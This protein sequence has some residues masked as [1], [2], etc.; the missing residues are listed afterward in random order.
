M[1]IMRVPI[2]TVLLAIT[3]TLGGA[4]WAGKKTPT[5]KDKMIGTWKATKAD[6]KDRVEFGVFTF[7]DDGKFTLERAHFL[8]LAKGTYT[9]DGDA[10]KFTVTYAVDGAPMD[11]GPW[12]VKVKSLSDKEIVLELK[13]EGSTA[14]VHF[15]RV[16]IPEGAWQAVEQD[17]QKL[18]GSW[19]HV[20]SEEAGK[21]VKDKEFAATMTFKGEKVVVTAEKEYG[22][23]TLSA[24]RK[25]KAIQFR[26]S[27]GQGLANLGA[28]QLDGDKLRIC[29]DP[30]RGFPAEFKTEGTQNR[31]DEFK[32]VKK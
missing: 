20:R 31:I 28:Y 4:V 18:Q 15:A 22:I 13:G 2:L 27:N 14:L 30:D 24:N 5:N 10:L 29:R 16:P 12:P 6:K 8:D 11:E 23:F 1:C 32:R 7:R 25:F 9:V 26:W 3:I 19:E 17:R 21:V